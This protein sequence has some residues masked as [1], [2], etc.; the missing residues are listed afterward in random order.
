MN[1]M[2]GKNMYTA[3]PRQS[4][5]RM[6]A[7]TVTVWLISIAT[8]SA[9]DSGS[10]GSDGA[11]NLSTPGS[12]MLSDFPADADGDNIY[13]F[14]SITIAAGVILDFRSAFSGPV[15]WLASGDVQIDGDILLD[16]QKGHPVTGLFRALPGAGGFSGG[17]GVSISNN[18]PEVGRGPGGGI[19]RSCGG[20]GGYLRDGGNNF[21]TN[22]SY[23]NP[24]ILPLIGGSGG[25]GSSRPLGTG[26]GGGGGA[27]LIASNTLIEVNGKISANGGGAFRG[28]PTDL[29]TS[30]GGGSG[31]AIKLMADIISGN[32]SLSTIGGFPDG[33][34]GTP[35]P[36]SQCEGSVGRIRI[37]A[38]QGPASLQILSPATFSTP[39]LVFLAQDQLPIRVVTIDGIAVPSN[40][41]GSFEMPDVTINNPSS[42]S[43][44]LEARGVPLNT[45]ITV[46][47]IPETGN[48]VSGNA[49]PLTG[50]VE[51]STA[52]VLLNIPAG[53]AQIFLKANF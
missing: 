14:T 30:G 33:G 23:G 25:G 5:R 2:R 40:P 44:A 43:I 13:H 4:F 22:N 18:T 11:L 17:I 15:I 26:G 20:G 51:I 41:T 9:F 46:T 6:I 48:V 39:G 12:I 7:R 31:G 24:F 28:D 35:N 10:D 38:L 34:D 29:Q 36:S 53:K 19:V 49:T 50:T 45:V 21:T 1:T 8:V 32:G 42:T 37:E 3:T 52:T 16:G 47:V 27:I